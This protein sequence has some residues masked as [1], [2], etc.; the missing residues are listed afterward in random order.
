MSLVRL[1]V[2][3]PAAPGNR[4]ISI[5]LSLGRRDFEEFI[6]GLFPNLQRLPFALLIADK[7]RWLHELPAG[8]ET[9]ADVRHQADVSILYIRPRRTFMKVHSLQLSLRMSTDFK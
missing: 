9:P 1:Y 7:Y 8:V 2:T 6:W 5:P 3:G 4:P